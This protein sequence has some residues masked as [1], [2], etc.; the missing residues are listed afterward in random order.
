[1]SI[2]DEI[3][4]TVESE[5]GL[6]GLTAEMPT[7]PSRPLI[8]WEWLSAESPDRPISEYLDHPLNFKQSEG[9][10]QVI[11][12]LEGMFGTMRRAIVDVIFGGMR[13]M[14]EGKKQND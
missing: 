10:A 8:S 4:G 9:L 7:Q 13:F 12:G 2:E 6:E 3:K 11:R 14:G 1:M 5:M